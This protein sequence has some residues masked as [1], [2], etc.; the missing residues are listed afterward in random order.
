MLN[1]VLNNSYYS[2]NERRYL[3][4]EVE[5][6]SDEEYVSKKTKEKLVVKVE[7]MS[8]QKNN[9]ID[10]EKLASEYGADASRLFCLFAAPVE[11]ELVWNMNGVVGAYRFI[12]RIYLLSLEL[13]D[14]LNKEYEPIDYDKRNVYDIE[15]QR[16][17]HNNY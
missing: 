1:G 13:K 10:P 5:K 9:G 15:V 14:I 12:N 4:E 11:N 8:N 6:I 17:L 7:K 2:Q 3:F 16:K